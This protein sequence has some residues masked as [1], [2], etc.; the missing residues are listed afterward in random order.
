MKSRTHPVG[1]CKYKRVNCSWVA[2]WHMNVKLCFHFIGSILCLKAISMLAS[3]YKILSF[4]NSY[5][6][7]SSF[8]IRILF[9][10]FSCQIVQVS[11]PGIVVNTYIKGKNLSHFWSWVGSCQSFPM[12]SSSSCGS[13][14]VFLLG[15][16]QLSFCLEYV[17]ITVLYHESVLSLLFFVKFF[18]L[19]NHLFS[20]L[21]L[22]ICL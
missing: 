16:G 15:W 18:F 17:A 3:M 14:A 19:E 7:V 2:E 22:F 9:I 20:S 8:P 21:H 10:L 11:S 6:F 5:H 13:S 12:K 1:C 4:A